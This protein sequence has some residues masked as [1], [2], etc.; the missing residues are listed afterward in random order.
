MP[1]ITTASRITRRNFALGNLRFLKA[2]M[3][4]QSI[5]KAC[6]QLEWLNRWAALGNRDQ[7]R[8]IV[9]KV[10]MMKSVSLKIFGLFIFLTHSS[11]W[12]CDFSNPH[13]FSCQNE[14]F[15]GRIF[16][17][18]PIN[19]AL[20]D[21]NWVPS[22]FTSRGGKSPFL[23]V[24]ARSRQ[25]RTCAVLNQDRTRVGVMKFRFTRNTIKDVRISQFGSRGRNFKSRSK[26]TFENDHTIV[27][28][29]G[30]E[31]FRCRIFQRVGAPHLTCQYFISGT[32]IGYLGLLSHQVSCN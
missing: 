14:T 15:A 9:E 7:S 2:I 5:D 30:S 22:Q 10:V 12:A 32:F 1:I 3:S 31:A 20:L 19:F 11:L 29:A 17:L 18:M 21:E 6:L 27:F 13:S 28:G 24:S 4:Y 26:I 23:T 16:P 8:F 25:T